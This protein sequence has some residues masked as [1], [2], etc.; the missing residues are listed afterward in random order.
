MSS[1]E[2]LVASVQEYIVLSTIRELVDRSKP[3][4]SNVVTSDPLLPSA[5]QSLKEI[6]IRSHMSHS[7]PLRS[8]ETWT[9]WLTE[10]YIEGLTGAFSTAVLVNFDIM[11]KVTAL[12]KDRIVDILRS[13]INEARFRLEPAE[14]PV[15]ATL[16]NWILTT[17]L[18]ALYKDLSSIAPDAVAF[19]DQPLAARDPIAQGLALK[20]FSEIRVTTDAI[21]EFYTHAFIPKATDIK[22]GL[23]E[24]TRLIT[25]LGMMVRG[26]PRSSSIE[27]AALL[28]ASSWEAPFFQHFTKLSMITIVQTV[29]KSVTDAFRTAVTAELGNLKGAGVDTLTDIDVELWAKIDE[30]AL[31]GTA[32]AAL[33]VTFPRPFST[34]VAETAV[35]IAHDRIVTFN[36]TFSGDI[37]DIVT[38]SGSGFVRFVVNAVLSDPTVVAGASAS[39]LI[40]EFPTTIL[41]M[42]Q[43]GRDSLRLN[44]RS[45]GAEL[46]Q[47]LSS[48][49]T[50]SWATIQ[51][52][53][54]VKITQ[55][56]TDLLKHSLTKEDGIAETVADFLSSLM[57]TRPEA[58]GNWA[59]E[60]MLQWERSRAHLHFLLTS[61]ATVFGREPKSVQAARL[62]DFWSSQ[63]ADLQSAQEDSNST[64]TQGPEFR[65]LRDT[66]TLGEKKRDLDPQVDFLYQRINDNLFEIE[67]AITMM[68]AHAAKTTKGFKRPGG[69]PVARILEERTA[70]RKAWA[71]IVA[72]SATLTTT[73]NDDYAKEILA[74]DN[75]ILG[76]LID[77]ATIPKRLPSIPGQGG[78]TF[79]NSARYAKQFL[80]VSLVTRIIEATESIASYRQ[81]GIYEHDSLRVEEHEIVVRPPRERSNRYRR[82][83]STV[84]TSTG[85]RISHYEPPGLSDD[86]NLIYVEKRD[87]ATGNYYMVDKLRE[88]WLDHEKLSVAQKLLDERIYETIVA[89]NRSLSP[90]EATFFGIVRRFASLLKN[91]SSN[92]GRKFYGGTL[93]TNGALSNNNIA[94]TGDFKSWWKNRNILPPRLWLHKVSF[95]VGVSDPDAYRAFTT[96]INTFKNKDRREDKLYFIVVRYKDVSSADAIIPTSVDATKTT[97]FRIKVDFYCT[98]I[99]PNQANALIDWDEFVRATRDLSSSVR[100]IVSRFSF[101]TKKSTTSLDETDLGNLLRGNRDR[102]GVYRGLFDTGGTDIVMDQANKITYDNLSLNFILDRHHRNVTAMV[103]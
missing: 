79:Q 64:A 94:D 87:A 1:Q 13:T 93:D 76:T 99:T 3:S 50:L 90:S 7:A 5:G 25:D 11:D 34:T 40:L 57:N 12:L 82:L 98:T 41:E 33:P 92:T 62:V 10:Q 18:P 47:W 37:E 68:K 96:T 15:D 75:G 51:S 53:L 36:T 89:T 65:A 23:M 27:T 16:P 32:I 80:T 88:R 22:P 56:T 55:A 42:V 72:D 78:R 19:F 97:T 39:P 86:F 49:P 61:R 29:S 69:V 6:L 38:E 35:A 30:S 83:R 63:F 43:V 59:K 24:L 70:M 17:H 85:R 100:R 81:V 46:N 77:N 101:G 20:I 21:I 4:A 45:T 2:A 14:G 84:M 74:K 58:N 67:R 44:L 48:A 31:V 95:W 52:Q 103:Y 91:S 102:D 54:K 73:Y 66:I 8:V 9:Q 26:V 28:S 60:S 71:E